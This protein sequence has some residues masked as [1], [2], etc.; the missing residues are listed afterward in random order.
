MTAREQP[1]AHAFHPALVV[2]WVLVYTDT[3]HRE[4]QSEEYVPA[5]S[6]TPINRPGRQLFTPQSS[7]STP[8]TEQPSQGNR[9]KR[10]H[11]A[12]ASYL[13]LGMETEPPHLERYAPALPPT[14]PTPLRS[15]KRARKK[16][17]G[18]Y[19]A[20]ND[21]GSVKPAKQT[22][23]PCGP[24]VTKPMEKKTSSQNSAT[25]SP[26]FATSALVLSPP[27]TT[28]KHDTPTL[29]HPIPQATTLLH[30]VGPSQNRS[31]AIFDRRSNSLSSARTISSST[32]DGNAARDLHAA[33]ALDLDSQNTMAEDE[34]DEI[35][36]MIDIDEAQPSCTIHAESQTA[37]SRNLQHSGTGADTCHF[38]DL[39]GNDFSDDDCLMLSGTPTDIT[40]SQMH[41]TKGPQQAT[42]QSQ[43]DAALSLDLTSESRLSKSQRHSHKSVLPMI[44]KANAIA[45]KPVVSSEEERKPIVRPLFPAP[46]RDRSPIIGLSPCL[47]LRTCFRIGEAIKEANHAAKSGQKVMFELYARVLSSQRNETKHGFVFRDLFH[48]KPPY[49]KGLYDA[50]IWRSVQLYEYDSERLLEEHRICRCIGTMRREGKE[51][52]MVVLNAWEAKWEDIDWVEGIVKT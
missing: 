6:F 1:N 52:V 22:R 39:S 9:G 51:W 25:T 48:A 26:G 40:S 4:H 19:L 29:A 14:P 27:S 20:T 18:N 43:S 15:R 35:F 34:F 49:L 3:A 30:A 11:E 47:L 2:I 50:V 42:E 28:W 17:D 36:N 12:V 46:V 37:D 24:R 8:F 16:H 44:P 41:C 32:R 10:H 21:A 23:K 7:T 13:G 5:S 33:H 31:K 45:R 38:L